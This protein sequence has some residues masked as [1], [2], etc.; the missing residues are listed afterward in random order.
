MN[1]NIEKIS[2]QAAHTYMHI[3][4]LSQP[5][6]TF[7]KLDQLD[8]WIKDQNKNHSPVNNFAPTVTKFCVMWEGQAL[9]HD[10]KF[11]NCRDK[12]L[13]G[14]TV[15][16][17]PLIHGPSWSGLKKVGPGVHFTNF[18]SIT[19]VASCYSRPNFVEPIAEFFCSWYVSFITIR[20]SVWIIIWAEEG[21]CHYH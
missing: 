1:C 21:A 20:E 4:N 11:R 15:P 7:I 2:L 18:L 19:I 17:W 3:S 12:I 6:P 8:P 16:N 10:T 9:P 14:R 13:E 5:G